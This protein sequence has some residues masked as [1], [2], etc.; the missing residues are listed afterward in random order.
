MCARCARPRSARRRRRCCGSWS[1][2]RCRSGGSSPR[3]ARASLGA[4]R[5]SSRTCAPVEVGD[6]DIALITL[7]E[8]TTRSGR[9]AQKSFSV[10]TANETWP[11]RSSAHARASLTCGAPSPRRIAAPGPPRPARASG[12]AGRAR[13]GARREIYPAARWRGAFLHTL[14][15]KELESSRTWASR[16]RFPPQATIFAEG[17]SCD[18]VLLVRSGLGADRG[19]RRRR[20][21]RWSWP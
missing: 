20:V 21:R 13:R 3:A 14:T 7:A 16:R 8:C 4:E 6:H 12:D 15:P 17:E 5:T 9:N 2:R 10:R 19:A 18:R 1:R 11:A